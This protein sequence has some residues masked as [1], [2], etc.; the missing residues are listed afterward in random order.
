MKV[1]LYT[2]SKANKKRIL[3]FRQLLEPNYLGAGRR[4]GNAKL[5]REKA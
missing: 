5:E 1:G 2:V 4:G 3:W